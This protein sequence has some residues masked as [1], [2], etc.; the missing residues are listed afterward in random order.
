[1]DIVDLEPGEGSLTDV[2][3]GNI[4]LLGKA[5]LTLKLLSRN[6]EATVNLVVADTLGLPELIKR[7][8]KIKSVHHSLISTLTCR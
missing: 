7:S 2:Q 4:P 1:M 5:K 6:I 8:R 3:G